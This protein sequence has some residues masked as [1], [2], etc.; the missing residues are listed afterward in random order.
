MH[1]AHPVFSQMYSQCLAPHLPCL[2]SAPVRSTPTIDLPSADPF[3]KR[4]FSQYFLDIPVRTVAF[5]DLSSNNADIFLFFRDV[6]L[7][8]KRP[9]AP[10]TGVDPLSYAYPTMDTYGLTWRSWVLVRLLPSPPIP[11]ALVDIRSLVFL[12]PRMHRPSSQAS[13]TSRSRPH[14]HLAHVHNARDTAAPHHPSLHLLPA[15]D[16]ALLL[17]S[18]SS[19]HR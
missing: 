4:S 3:V 12:S 9:S 10:Y 5:C 19:P 13:Q 15:H 11:R 6:L 17:S 8:L 14:Q 16:I 1:E 7:N 2:I 18:R